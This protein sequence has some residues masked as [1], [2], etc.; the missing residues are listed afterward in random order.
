MAFIN[1]DRLVHTGEYIVFIICLNFCD[2]EIMKHL[3]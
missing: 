3:L 1:Q 2:K